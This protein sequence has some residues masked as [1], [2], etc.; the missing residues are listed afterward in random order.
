M[1]KRS[2]VVDENKGNLPYM[3]LWLSKG[4]W[5]STEQIASYTYLLE[6]KKELEALGLNPILFITLQNITKV[7]ELRE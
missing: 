5:L 2:F 1:V 4:G 3:I 6:R 7:E